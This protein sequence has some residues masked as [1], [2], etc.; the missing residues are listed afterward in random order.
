VNYERHRRL[1]GIWGSM[2]SRCSNPNVEEYKYYGAR[3]I[4]VCAEWM[5]F[6]P[7][8]EWAIRSGYKSNLSIDRINNDGGYCPDNCR[9][10]TMK[11]QAQNR[12]SRLNLPRGGKLVI[13]AGNLG[14]YARTR[15]RDDHEGNVSRYIRTLIRR[16]MKKGATA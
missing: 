6:V 10:A 11:Q 3:G 2:K 8:Y 14:A 9:W 4:A 12:R 5:E 7:F 16:D 15:A 1:L 13:S